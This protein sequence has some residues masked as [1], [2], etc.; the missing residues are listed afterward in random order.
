MQSNT[1]TI[2][3]KKSLEIKANIKVGSWPY[4]VAF[5]KKKK[6][7]FV[8]NQ[9]DNSISIIDISK[10]KLVK[11]LKEV[12][13]YPEGIDISYNENLIV[14]ACWFEDNIILLDLDNYKL[15]EKINVSG[16]PRAFGN[17]ILDNYES[18]DYKLMSNAVR[19]LSIDAIEKANSGHPGMPLGMADVATVLFT[20]FLKFDPTKPEWIDRD[21]FILSA[22]HGSMLLYALSHLV[23]YKDSSINQI[24]NFRQLGAKQQVT[25]NMDY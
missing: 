11:T 8:T 18:K 15:I 6:I 14:V 21:R 23:G 12:C 22:G 1:I 9:R 2:I 20:K 5:E 4:Q 13:E 10:L 16:G 19:A 17:F 25:L 7:L 3:N 24:K